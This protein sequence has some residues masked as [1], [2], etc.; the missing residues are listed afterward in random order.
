[1]WVGFFPVFSREEGK[2]KQD[3]L[4]APQSLRSPGIG[5][6]KMKNSR[7]ETVASDFLRMSTNAST[8]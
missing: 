1:M 5:N 4:G 8:S 7:C 2:G 6:H 3:G